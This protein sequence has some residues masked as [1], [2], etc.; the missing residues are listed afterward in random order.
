MN[1]V[2]KKRNDD[3]I[4]WNIFGKLRG[5]LKGEYSNIDYLK[6]NNI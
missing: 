3:E 6:I 2:G 5:H 1:S 4:F